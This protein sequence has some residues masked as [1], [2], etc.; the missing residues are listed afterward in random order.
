M[1]DEDEGDYVEMGILGAIAFME[2]HWSR[3][4]SRP[5]LVG[6]APKLVL[7]ESPE[8]D[9]E[10]LAVFRAAFPLL[11]VAEL[12]ESD[13]KEGKAREEWNRFLELHGRGAEEM[14]MLRRD[15]SRGC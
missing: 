2:Q 11:P 15:S 5:V 6:A 8:S 14:T 7:T 13:L 4:E 3:I 9:A 10:L 1:A 12:S